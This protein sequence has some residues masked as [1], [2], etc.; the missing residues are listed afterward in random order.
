MIAYIFSDSESMDSNITTGLS[1]TSLSSIQKFSVKD[2]NKSKG[3]CYM[4]ICL[5]MHL[6]D[7]FPTKIKRS[8][9]FTV[10]THSLEGNFVM[11]HKDVIALLRVR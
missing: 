6:T 2:G 10:T 3:Q 8:M 5:P 11:Y 1:L 9:K 7:L 4:G